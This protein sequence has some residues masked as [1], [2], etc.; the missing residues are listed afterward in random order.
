MCF[1]DTL[2]CLGEHFAHEEEMFDTYGFGEH[3]N[4]KL[5][6]KRSHAAEHRRLLERVQRELDKGSGT[7]AASFIKEL[8]KD[9]RT[10]SICED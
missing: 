6:A 8:L 2:T 9:G 4:E 7:V 1:K 5:S 3:V 10:I